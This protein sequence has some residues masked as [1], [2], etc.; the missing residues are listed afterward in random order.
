MA[1]LPLPRS[2]SPATELRSG[3]L[4]STVGSF[5]KSNYL[6][7][8]YDDKTGNGRRSF[9]FTGWTAL[10]ANVAAEEYH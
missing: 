10:V 5:T 6:W 7:E 3:L 4:K 1:W 8:Q 9:P 2:P